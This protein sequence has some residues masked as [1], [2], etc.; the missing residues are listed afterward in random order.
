MQS[1]ESN[2]QCVRVDR[3]IFVVNLRIIVLQLYHQDYYCKETGFCGAYLQRKNLFAGSNEPIFEVGWSYEQKYL[4][5]LCFQAHK[6]FC[7]F[8]IE[9]L[10][11]YNTFDDSHIN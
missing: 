2:E 6:S 9:V 7:G 5:I 11:I 8:E 1:K 3:I 10:T 4:Q